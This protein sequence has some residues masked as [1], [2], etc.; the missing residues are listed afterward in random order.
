[1][2]IVVLSVGASYASAPGGA[3]GFNFV[4]MK[5]HKVQV[6]NLVQR[7]EKGVNTFSGA[8]ANDTDMA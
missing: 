2:D 5:I 6:E 3:S 8:H 1:V 4:S 7:H